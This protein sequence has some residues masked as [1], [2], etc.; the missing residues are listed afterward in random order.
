MSSVRPQQPALSAVRRFVATP[1][2]LLTILLTILVAIAAPW[3]VSFLL[4]VVRPPFDKSWRAYYG[5]VGRDA[6]TSAQQVGLAIAFLPHQAW[7]SADAILRTLWRLF[8][9]RRKLLE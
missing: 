2:G 1:K 7:V 9:T 4:A 3:I 6:L 5:A 8:V